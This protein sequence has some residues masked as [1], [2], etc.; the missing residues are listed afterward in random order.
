MQVGKRLTAVSWACSCL[1]RASAA[2]AEDAMTRMQSWLCVHE[3]FASLT[4]C[5]SCMEQI[6]VSTLCK[7]WLP[8]PANSGRQYI[9]DSHILRG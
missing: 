4:S 5:T 9:V 1:A 8:D 3:I 2:A 6:A 7:H